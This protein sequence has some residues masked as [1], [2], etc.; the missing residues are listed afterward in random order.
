MTILKPDSFAGKSAL[1]TGGM[2]FVGSNLVRPEH[3]PRGKHQSRF[4]PLMISHPSH[5]I[6]QWAI[7]FRYV[8]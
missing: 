2:G 7:A 3:P 4:V 6:M 5:L 8:R 1:I